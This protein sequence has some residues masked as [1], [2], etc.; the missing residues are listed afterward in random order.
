M[1]HRA[2]M[3]KLTADFEARMEEMRRNIAEL[4]KSAEASGQRANTGLSDIMMSMLLAGGGGGGGGHGGHG[5]SPARASGGRTVYTGP[6][7]GRYYLTPSGNKQ[8][9]RR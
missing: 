4:K 5:G 6:R 3:Q 2:A 8:Y 9:L 7:G 1:E